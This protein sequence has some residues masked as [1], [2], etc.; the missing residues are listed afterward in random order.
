[1][2]CSDNIPRRPAVFRRE[3][4]EEWMWGR[5]DLGGEAGGVEE[6]ETLI[7]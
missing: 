7:I 3:K 2:L 1:M 4:K 6:G 5:E